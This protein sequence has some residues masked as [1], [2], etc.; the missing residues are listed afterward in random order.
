MAAR[1]KAFADGLEEE[2]E[3]LEEHERTRKDADEA[4]DAM[5]VDVPREGLPGEPPAFGT[6]GSDLA[7]NAFPG[8]G[9]S[10]ETPFSF[11]SR[12]LPWDPVPECV[13]CGDDGTSGFG[14]RDEHGSAGTRYCWL[15]RRQRAFAPS[16]GR[17]RARRTPPN[18]RRERRASEEEASHA[19][20]PANP[21][22]WTSTKQ[23]KACVPWRTRW[24]R[25]SASVSFR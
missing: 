24:T 18:T 17:A 3:T 10:V 4:E 20:R 19:L 9:D 1:Q 6:A 14:E 15:A 25:W 12:R 21:K 22:T 16:A 2:S 13:L 5:D 7:A 11:S 8:M 23:N